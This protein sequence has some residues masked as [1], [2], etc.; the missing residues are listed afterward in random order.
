MSTIT[1][2][3]RTRHISPQQGWTR[4]PSRRKRAPQKAKESR[5][6]PIPAVRILTGSKLL[7]YRTYA[8]AL[9]S[10]PTGSLISARPHES[11][12][13]D[14]VGLVLVVC[15]SLPCKAFSF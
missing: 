15:P 1:S 12:L 9:R 14:S 11:Q 4:Q 3:T 10:D 2:Y 13:V 5:E 7:S 6:S 8:E